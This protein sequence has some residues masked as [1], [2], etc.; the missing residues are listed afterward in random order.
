MDN[1][2]AAQDTTPY[3]DEELAHFKELLEEEHQQTKEEIEDLNER[4]KNLTAN[5]EDEQ[6]GA[7]HHQGDIGSEED[8]REKFLIMVEKNKEKMAEINAALDRIELGTYGVCE[9]TGQK[10]QKERLEAIPHA[11]LSIGAQEN[12]EQE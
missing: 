12:H 7:A 11:R 1:R 6:S 2:D 10:I 8:E 3:S 4:V 9:E 5:Q